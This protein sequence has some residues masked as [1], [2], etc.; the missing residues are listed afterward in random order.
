MDL[1]GHFIGPSCKIRLQTHFFWGNESLWDLDRSAPVLRFFFPKKTRRR[2]AQGSGLDDAGNVD[3]LGPCSH[4]LPKA[5]QPQGGPR[6][7][8]G[9]GSA[10]LAAGPGGLFHGGALRQGSLDLDLQ[11]HAT[12]ATKSS[13]GSSD[14]EMDLAPF[15]SNLLLLIRKKLPYQFIS[16]KLW[17]RKNALEIQIVDLRPCFS[18]EKSL[19]PFV[20]RI[21]SGGL[22]VKLWKVCNFAQVLYTAL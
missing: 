2:R 3:L 14:L 18:G 5:Y 20:D 15:D 16:Y 7:Q 12:Q 6:A 13:P 11:A 22:A 1:I 4:L 17:Y 9:V 19:W 8:R 10:I 21:T